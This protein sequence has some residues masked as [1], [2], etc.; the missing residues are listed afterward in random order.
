MEAA[1]ERSQGETVTGTG[2][3]PDWKGTAMNPNG[4]LRAHEL[5][6]RLAPTGENESVRIARAQYDTQADE[7]KQSKMAAWR[8]MIEMQMADNLLAVIGGIEG[9]RVI[10]LA[11]GDGHYSRWL[12]REK[13]AAAVLGVDLSESMINLANEQEAKE[14][15]GI[16]FTCCDAAKLGHWLAADVVFAAYLLNYASNYQEL[17]NFARSIYAALP[18]GGIFVTVQNAPHDTACN[19]PELRKYG[20]VKTCSAPGEE[21]AVIQYTFFAEGHEL[22]TVNNYFLSAQTHE[23]AFHEV[24]FRCVG[25][26]SPSRPTTNLED[27]EDGYWEDFITASP[28][29]GIFALK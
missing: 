5:I 4:Q 17:V 10:D 9:K 18:E 24:G 1:P 25:Y 7:Y 3:A 14:P 29:E 19:H 13:N 22:C 20:L 6:A 21:G 16:Q 11:C 27:F 23:R 28:I 15:L 2:S 26:C 8:L 12:K